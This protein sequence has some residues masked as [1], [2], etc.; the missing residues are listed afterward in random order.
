MTITN[1]FFGFFSDPYKRESFIH[2]R[3][4]NRIIET[5]SLVMGKIETCLRF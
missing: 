3:Q 4:C 1:L 5:N 2:N